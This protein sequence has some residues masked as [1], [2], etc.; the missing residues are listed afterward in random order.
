MIVLGSVP[1]DAPAQLLADW[2]EL[3][4]LLAPSRTS[5]ITHLNSS[6]E[7]EEDQEPD[8]FDEENIVEEN[9]ALKAIS[10]IEER[11]RQ[12]GNDYPFKMDDSGSKL[13]MVDA[14][15][16]G[17]GIY[18]L[19]LVVS[20]AA[21]DGLLHGHAL[22]PDLTPTR[23][24]FQ[25]C[26]TLCA[27]G[28]CQGPAFSFGWPRPDGSSFLVKLAEIYGL[29]GDGTPR[30]HAHA[31]A[32]AHV[33]DESIDV[34][35]WRSEPDG[36]ADTTYVLGQAASGANWR[37]KSVKKDVEFFHQEWFEIQPATPA[38]PVM[39]MPF[40]LEDPSESKDD[41]DEWEAARGR[42]ARLVREHGVIMD[43]YRVARYASRGI[44]LAAEGVSPIER[45]ETVSVI[46]AWVA[47]YRQRVMGAVTA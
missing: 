24:L 17:G 2:L 19:C 35:A 9:R 15:T 8:D 37:G 6:V 47:E 25:A 39:F 45:L 13:E 30:H 26:A 41:L 14:W 42:H 44:L 43:R 27:A 7:L 22:A 12:L 5:L 1:V 18:L 36:R 33:K 4:A 3:V 28:Y 16:P 40:C 31:G 20:S 38:M 11:A 34:I 29:F 10:L 32:P 21:R 23:D 46:S